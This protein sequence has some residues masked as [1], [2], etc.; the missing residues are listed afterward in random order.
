MARTA[1]LLARGKVQF[2]RCSLHVDFQPK[3]K[4]GERRKEKERP[5]RRER[6][7]E[8]KGSLDSGL[9]NPLLSKWCKMGLKKVD[10]LVK[11]TAKHYVD[12]RS[13][14]ARTSQGPLRQTQD[15]EPTGNRAGGAAS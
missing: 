7:S 14:E 6:E 5:T 11:C 2:H 1:K 4:W 3:N 9:F 12:R 8:R 15:E 10:V 13:V